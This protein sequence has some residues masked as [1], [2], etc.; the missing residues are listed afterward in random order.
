MTD[1]TGDETDPGGQAQDDPQGTQRKERLNEEGGSAS[2]PRRAAENPP[3]DH[4]PG[5]GAPDDDA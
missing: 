1:P 3:G 5:Q 4:D 2:D